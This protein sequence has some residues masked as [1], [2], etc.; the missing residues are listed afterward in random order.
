MPPGPDAPSGAGDHLHRASGPRPTRPTP[1]PCGWRCSMAVPEGASTL[2]SW[3]SSIISAVANHGAAISAKRIMSTAPMAKLG[4]TTQPSRARAGKASARVRQAPLHRGRSCRSPS[5]CRGPRT[6]RRWPRPR[7]ATVKSTATSAPASIRASSSAAM[8]VGAGGIRSGGFAGHRLTA[9]PGPRRQPAPGRRRRATAAHTVEPIRPAAPMTPTLTAADS[10]R[11][12]RSV[13]P[14]GRPGARRRR[15]N[16][17]DARHR[18]GARQP[19]GGHVV[20]LVQGQAVET[21][22]DLVDGQHPPVDDL[23][24]ADPAHAGPGVLQSEGHRPRGCGPGRSPARPR[25]RLRLAIALE[26]GVDQF[27]AP[28]RCWRATCRRTRPG[29]RRPGRP[30]GRRTPS[31]PGPAPPG[32]PGT[33]GSTSRRPSTCST[34]AMA[35]RSSSS[36]SGAGDATARWACSV[37]PGQHGAPAAAARR[38]RLRRGRVPRHGRPSRAVMPSTTWSWSSSPAAAT[39]TLAGR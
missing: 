35:W 3:C 21:G 2:A 15:S 8:T 18:L 4:A 6:T 33:A 19:A 14:R 25:S 28:R 34:I 22:V 38:G 5:G 20:D 17:P 16:G 27:A 39:T 23:A 24:V 12:R 29:P 26:L 13:V 7:P 10:S 32:W 1:R 37:V 9:P 11:V 30:A 36:R 31:R